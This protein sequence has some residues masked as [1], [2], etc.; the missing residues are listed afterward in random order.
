MEALFFCLESV[1]LAA[2]TRL[3]I[4]AG[5]RWLPWVTGATAL[6]LALLAVYR[7]RH[8]LVRHGG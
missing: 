7:A 1:V 4:D 2:M 8:P 6:A 3:S 5:K